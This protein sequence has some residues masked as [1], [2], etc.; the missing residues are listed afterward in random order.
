MKLATAVKIILRCNLQF[1]NTRKRA[2]RQ[3]N[4]KRSFLFYLMLA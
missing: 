3:G 4:S 2:A 1:N